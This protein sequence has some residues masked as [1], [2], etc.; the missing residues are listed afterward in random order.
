MHVLTGVFTLSLLSSV[1]LGNSFHG[2]KN[3]AAQDSH[4]HEEHVDS[5]ETDEIA[6]TLSSDTT[7]NECHESTAQVAIASPSGQR[8]AEGNA[9]KTMPFALAG[10]ATSRDTCSQIFLGRIAPLFEHASLFAATISM[11]I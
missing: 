8:L 6:S 10:S 11:R 1:V 4:H 7:E 2:Q 3:V 9:V 5:I